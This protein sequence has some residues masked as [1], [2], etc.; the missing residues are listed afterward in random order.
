M[1]MKKLASLLLALA[2]CAGLAVPA[3]AA[4]FSDVP[5][6][7]P[8]YQGIMDCANTGVTSGYADGTFK[9]GNSVTKAQFCVMLSRAFCA[10]KIQEY[11]TDPYKK[12]WY[13][14]G[15]KALSMAGAL[16]STSFEYAFGEPRIMNQNI[17]RYDM[18]QLM[19]N[20]MKAG[21]SAATDAQKSAAQTRIVDYGSVPGQYRD[22]VKNV[23]ALGIITGYADG[24]FGGG[25]AMNRGQGCVVIYRMLQY[26]PGTL[27]NGKPITEENVLA[28]IQELLKQYPDGMKWDSNTSR[29]GTSSTAVKQAYKNYTWNNT[30]LSTT[31]G[32]SGFASQISDAIFGNNDAN[33]IRKTSTHCVRPGDIVIMLTSPGKCKHVIIAASTITGTDIWGDKTSPVIASYEGN[34]NSRVSYTDYRAIPTTYSDYNGYYVEVWTRYPTDGIP[35]TGADTSTATP[36]GPAPATAPSAPSS[37][38]LLAG[39]AAAHAN[40]DMLCAVCGKVIWNAGAGSPNSSM[41]AWDDAKDAGVC[42]TCQP[43]DA[44]RKALYG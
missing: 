11:N 15:T 23:F 34:F 13:G 9:P 5:A 25:K 37:G 30:S 16:E 6:G 19:T 42:K 1:N 29:T 18:A 36:T 17:T 41:G 31:S 4:D 35:W 44:G 26:T 32:C 27:A 12:T 8:F 38:S 10:D 3:L 21:G 14:P 2:L 33:P 7:H 40:S 22:A 43:T 20:I 24:S 39:T 28:I